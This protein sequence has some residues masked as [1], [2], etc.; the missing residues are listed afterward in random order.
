MIKV[1]TF[2]DENIKNK[3]LNDEVIALP[4]DTV[5][6]F[7][8]K[9]DSPIAYQKLIDIKGR[10]PDKPIALMFAPNYD[11]SNIIEVDCNSKK[12]IA[13]FFPGQVT[14]ILKA[15]NKVPY[16]TH[17]GSKKIGFRITAKKELNDFIASLNFPLQVTSANI[18]GEKTLTNYQEVVDKFD[19]SDV[20]M[21]VKGKCDSQISTTVVDL[22]N[23]KPVLIRE[24]VIKFDDILKVY[25]GG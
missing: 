23:D 9:Y 18:S 12:V 4:T 21:I 6:G 10:S 20:S 7:A 16:Q 22:S 2:L 19:N 17:L 25:Y 3:L 8:I 14:L 1:D 24:G 11:Y 13:K 15:R 5:Y